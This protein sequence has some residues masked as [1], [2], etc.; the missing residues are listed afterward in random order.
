MTT[1]PIAIVDDL[2][3]E[4]WPSMDLVAEM[5]MTVLVRDHRAAVGVTRIC[6]PMKRRFSLISRRAFHLA[7]A[8]RFC[9]RFWDYP[10]HVR[11]HRNSFDVFHIIDHSYSQLAHELPPNRT[12]ITCHD[13]D[14]FRCLFE[15]SRERRSFPFRAMMRR[16]LDGFR[17]AARV[18]CDT[19]AIRD[20]LRAYGLFPPE[21]L[22]VV[23]NGVH[24][25]CTTKP[26]PPADIKAARLL[27]PERT[28]SIEILH[29]GS[30]IPRKRIDVLLEVVAAVRKEF[31]HARLIRA[32]GRFSRDQESQLSRLNLADSVVVL[33]F[34]DRAVLAAI[35]RRAALV[36]L[37]SDREGFGLP[38]IEAMACGTPVVGS[39]IPALREVGG[40]AVTYCPVG[41]VPTW[42]KTVIEL[43][44]E[45]A[46]KPEKWAERRAA[47][48]AQASK[49]TWEEYA[50]KMVAIYKEVLASAA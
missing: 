13:L 25:S 21:R 42:S 2:G 30:T 5:L 14:T 29:V 41:D 11:R 47:G 46:K 9:N 49:F 28:S 37:L 38:V 24:P 1:F 16:V 23:P 22:T 39:D 33:P 12:I 6:P 48:I 7:N 43:L 19:A 50:S 15:P 31:P 44:C 32:G 45:R 34:L 10:R 40:E 17:K 18:T 35:Y 20:E 8:D 26:D 3:Q 36:L 4:G 27:G